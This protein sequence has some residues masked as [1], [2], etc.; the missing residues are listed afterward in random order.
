MQQTVDDLVRPKQGNEE[1]AVAVQERALSSKD[2]VSTP[3]GANVLESQSAE[4]EG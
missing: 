3:D 1:G 4:A 2:K